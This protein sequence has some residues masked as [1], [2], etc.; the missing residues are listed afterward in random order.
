MTQEQSNN[1]KQPSQEL[2]NLL[3]Q[4]K[5]NISTLKDLYHAIDKKALE[6]GFSI[7]EIYEIANATNVRLKSIVAMPDNDNNQTT[8][9]TT[10]ST[11]NNDEENKYFQRYFQHFQ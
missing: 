2:F 11:D 9:T 4:L 7:E 3:V 5:T 10:T 6:E 8:T 1:N